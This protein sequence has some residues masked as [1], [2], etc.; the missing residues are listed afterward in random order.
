MAASVEFDGLASNYDS[1]LED[2]LRGRFGSSPDFFHRCKW[3]MIQS[4]LESAHLN[5]AHMDWLDVG[6]GRGELL[7]LGA[8]SFR[9]AEGCEPS[10]E[11]IRNGQGRIHWQRDLNTLPFA[12]SS[13]DFVT[14]VCV[15]HHVPAVNRRPLASEVFRVLRPNG[16]FCLIEHNPFNPVTRWIVSRTPVDQD[17][18]LLSPA[19]SRT[20][21]HEVGFEP[22]H[23]RYFLYS[24]EQWYERL[25]RWETLLRRFPVGGQYSVFARKLDSNTAEERAR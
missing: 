10:R 4:Y 15:F 12:A 14:A 1:L 17:A 13:Y 3:E 6:C 9:R 19:L 16:I 25:G 21:L 24:P 20:I 22:V 5:P 7:K 23:T 11:M 2:P 8:P 18:H